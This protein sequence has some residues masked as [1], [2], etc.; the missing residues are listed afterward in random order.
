MCPPRCHDQRSV[1]SGNLRVCAN[2]NGKSPF[3][4]ITDAEVSIACDVVCHTNP[5]GDPIGG[6]ELLDADGQPRSGGFV[7]LRTH[8]TDALDFAVVGALADA[9]EAERLASRYARGVD[10]AESLAPAARYWSRVTRD[11]RLGGGGAGV[12]AVNTILPWLARTPWCT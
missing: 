8:P 7:A 12:A 1:A 11:L 4:E 10:G 9:A 2:G 5:C 6:D 3:G